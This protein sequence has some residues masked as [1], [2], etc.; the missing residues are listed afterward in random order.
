MLQIAQR[1]LELL[2][3]RP[4]VLSAGIPDMLTVPGFCSAGV[5]SW[6]H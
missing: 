3:L 1:D 6:L 4:P 2:T 5:N